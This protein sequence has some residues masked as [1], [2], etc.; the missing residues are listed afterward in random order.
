MP[1]II[2][3]SAIIYTAGLVMLSLVKIN[4]Q[5]T[6]VKF[7]NADKVFHYSAYLGLTFLWQGRYLLKN[8]HKTKPHI[9]LS[10]ILISFGIVIEILQSSTTTYRSFEINDILANSAGVLTA[11]LILCFFNPVRKL[12]F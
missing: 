3:F 10:L 2:L 11:H 8:S 9:G 7:N 4:P 12:K 6:G 1:K 5:D